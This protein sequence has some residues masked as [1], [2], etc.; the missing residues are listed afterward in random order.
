[1]PPR[2]GRDEWDRRAAA[3]V[4]EWV[5]DEPIYSHTKHAA[6]CLSCGHEWFGSPKQIAK[7]QGCPSCANQ[8][9]ADARVLPPVEWD[10]RA[11][12][13]S[14]RW[15]G[16]EPVRARTKHAAQCLTCGH[17]WRVVPDSIARGSGC[18]ACASNAPISRQEWDD[19]ASVLSIEWT[20]DEPFRA[21]EPHA[22]RCLKCGH[23][24][25][26]RPGNVTQG[27]GC[28][29]C[30][31]L[32]RGAQSRLTPEEWDR[33]AAAGGME[34]VDQRPELIGDK[35][36]ARCLDC[37]TEWLAHSV[38][39]AH[40]GNGCPS[41]RYK[42]VADSMILPREEWDRRAAAKRVE[43]VGDEPVWGM[44]KR[45][46]RCLTCGHEWSVI[47]DSVYRASGCPACAPNAP[48]SRE[49]QDRRA[50]AVSIEWVG[51][52]PF[53]SVEP[54]AARC[55][56]C[57]WEFSPRPSNVSSGQ[58]CPACSPR[59]FDPVAPATVY[60]MRHDAGPFVKVGITGA[61]PST[62]LTVHGRRGWEILGTWPI[63]VGRDAA[64]IEGRVVEWWQECGATRCTKDEIPKG[65]GWT[66]AV[67]ITAAA[68]EPRTIAYIEELVAEVG[69]GY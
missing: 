7:G 18:P 34:W 9:R 59:G 48:V 31:N 17:E 24:W 36:L 56:K 55:L 4:L 6:R 52:E 27:R 50:A 19:R 12:V 20:G 26:P 66:E 29:V 60:L 1:M 63:P 30:A 13:E 33:R 2:I 22:A 21:L 8:K 25:Q 49:E 61:D 38:T 45:A 41:C 35:R 42:K 23:E 64:V 10:R 62:R 65:D 68:D 11:A 39:V 14:I 5:G 51:E 53:S 28:P 15:V 57:G 47:P 32:T 44:K 3:A 69:G 40:G 16:D 54:H 46:A 58:G 37:A 43:W 67:H